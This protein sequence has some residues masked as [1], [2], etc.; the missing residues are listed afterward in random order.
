MI[1]AE[2]NLFYHYWDK[3]KILIVAGLA[4]VLMVVTRVS[5]EEIRKHVTF[6]LMDKNTFS[7]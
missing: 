3:L 2:E 7:C 5:H 1:V 6:K 4:S